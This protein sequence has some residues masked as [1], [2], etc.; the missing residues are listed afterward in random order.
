MTNPIFLFDNSY[1]R[2]PEYFYS[3]INPQK[4]KQPELIHLNESLAADLNLPIERLKTDKQV[5]VFAGNRIPERAEPLAMAYTGHQFGNFNPQLGDGRAILLGE[6]LNNKQERFDVQLKGSGRTPYSRGGDG[7]A[8]M[9]P[10]L[11][12]YI[13]CEFMHAAGI[14]T[15]RALAAVSTGENIMREHLLPGAI[16]TRLSR[17]YVRVGTFQLFATQQNFQAV[18]E[19]ADYVITRNYPE[20]ASAENPYQALLKAVIKRQAELIAQWMQIGF[21][22]GVMNTDNASIVGETIDYG[23]CAFM[24]DYHA[25][26]VYSSID[27]QGRYAY[28]N[29]PSIAHW[30]MCRFAETL[31][32][33]LDENTD[34]GVTIAQ[35]AIN[36]YSDLYQNNWLKGMRKKLGLE[37]SDANDETLINDLLGIMPTHQADFTLTFRGLSDASLLPDVLSHAED[38]RQWQTHWHQRLETEKQSEAYRQ[39]LILAANPIYIPRNHLVEEVIRS[40]EDHNE[41]KPFNDLIELLKKP[42]EKQNTPDKYTQAPPT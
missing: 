41:L 35:D 31:I 16:I 26:T 9:G 1:A 40:A 4:V 34:T 13:M 7:R 19:L 18:R 33:L 17:S 14:P 10:V 24:D 3:R 36:T 6:L 28:R 42:F 25:D 12:E 21:I 39:S 29:Q 5:A 20:A 38:F 2:L 8:A 32:P 15:T 11:R 37:E 23:P 27:R 30:N 22:H